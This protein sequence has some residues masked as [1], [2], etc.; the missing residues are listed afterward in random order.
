MTTTVQGKLDVTPVRL[1]RFETCGETIDAYVES[2]D[3]TAVE[4]RRTAL[5]KYALS[6]AF[7]TTAKVTLR[8]AAAAGP[9]QVLDAQ[10]K[11]LRE[12][13]AGGQGYSIEIA[14]PV[15]VIDR[16]ALDRDHLG[17]AVEIGKIV[18]RE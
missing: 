18:V 5:G 9:L 7:G 15:T 13:A 11:M 3:G 6:P 16:A 10:G 17:P 2:I 4:A 12:V 1:A 14:G 8:L